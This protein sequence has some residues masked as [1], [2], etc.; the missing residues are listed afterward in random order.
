MDYLCAAG[1]SQRS[2]AVQFGVPQQYI[3]RHFRAHVS[4]RYKQMVGASHNE[5]FEQLVAAATEANS[6]S[7]SL[8]NLIIRGHSSMWALALEASDHKLMTAHSSRILQALEVR[9]RITMELAP[10]GGVTINNFL[11]RDAAELVNTLR[12]N[13]DAVA[14]IENWYRWRTQGRLIEA[15]ADAEAAD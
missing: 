12:D 9:S 3:N 10:S 11:L 13:E 4:E 7:V 8:L 5:T 15:K 6:E 1:A 2:V 14:K